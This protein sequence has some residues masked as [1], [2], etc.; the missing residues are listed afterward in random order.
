MTENHPNT[1]LERVAQAVPLTRYNKWIREQVA[2]WLAL[3]RLYEQLPPILSLR[4]IESPELVE[5][6]DAL[7]NLLER[8]ICHEPPG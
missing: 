6:A 2:D 1:S 8:W 3:P 4:N 7:R 5:K